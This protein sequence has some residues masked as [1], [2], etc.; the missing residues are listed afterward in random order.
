MAI[1]WLQTIF[2]VWPDL[3]P[4]CFCRVHHHH[5]HKPK[6]HTTRTGCQDFSDRP[7]QNT[8]THFAATDWKHWRKNSIVFWSR[9]V[10]GD[11]FCG[12]SFFLPGLIR[13]RNE[14]VCVE[15]RCIS[16]HAKT[17]SSRIP[18]LLIPQARWQLRSGICRK[19][20]SSDFIRS[21]VVPI[22]LRS[23]FKMPTFREMRETSRPLR[24][25]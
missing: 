3:W 15:I 14:S 22:I 13:L 7:G 12:W 11:V 5:H 17:M 9:N 16:L 21:P 20:F 6:Q 18:D 23:V 2:P 1:N 19:R 4:P 10:D 24:V 8:C 25:V